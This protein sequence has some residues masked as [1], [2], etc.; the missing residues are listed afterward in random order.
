MLHFAKTPQFHGQAQ[1]K[2]KSTTSIT[3]INDINEAW[4][5]EH[6]KHATRLLPGGIYILG[7]FVISN[8]DLLNPL[9]PKL[10]TILNVIHK[11]L[12]NNKYLKGNPD[13]NEKLI[14]N[15]CTKTGSY[16]C[17]SYDIN[18]T[19]VKSV[20]FK[21]GSQELQKWHEIECYYDLDQL[22]PIVENDKDLPL[23]K[24]MSVCIVNDNLQKN[25]HMLFSN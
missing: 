2:A 19:S 17:K 14:L 20:I 21:F 23:K 11:Q 25:C 7:I 9:S 13:F 6:A 16:T 5:A 3:T 24:H 18:T 12:S 10:K 8:D 15:Y 4:I 22:I 1:E